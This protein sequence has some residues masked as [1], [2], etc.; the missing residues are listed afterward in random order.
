MSYHHQIS[1]NL[2]KLD[3]E[4]S[5][6]KKDFEKIVRYWY[7]KSLEEAKVTGHSIES[8]TYTILEGIEDGLSQTTISVED[9]L[10]YSLEIIIDLLH[11]SA[12]LDIQKCEKRL[13]FAKEA[14]EDRVNSERL[15]IIDTI[16]TF[17]NYAKDSNY[18]KF[19]DSLDKVALDMERYI[20]RLKG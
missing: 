19:K 6:V 14:L 12:T 8:M 10:S 1:Q 20:D 17:K 5:D 4:F 7:S 16:E 18:S 2:A 13:N 3:G 15:N 11:H 9:G